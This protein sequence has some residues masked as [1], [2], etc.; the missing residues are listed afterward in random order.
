MNW[1]K[2]R[3]DYIDDDKYQE[4][5]NEL[6]HKGVVV[7]HTLIA[8]LAKKYHG[9]PQ[10]SL[11]IF[12]QKLRKSARVS[13]QNLHK[14]LTKLSLLFNFSF[15]K[16]EEK[17][18]FCYPKFLEIQQRYKRDGAGHFVA[19][20]EEDKRI[21]NKDKRIKSKVFSSTVH[22]VVSHLIKLMQRNDPK[23]KIPENLDTWF[24]EADRLIRLD[25]REK[26]EVLKVITF[27]QADPFWKSN[28]LSMG[29]L[30]EKYT[31]LK[32]KMEGNNGKSGGTNQ[33]TK[34]KD[35]DEGA[36]TGYFG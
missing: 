7:W 29:K 31:Q 11:E 18:H 4:C 36:P 28:I 1:F 24:L 26:D 9:D 27:S 19:I 25:K 12:E 34:E 8:L 10:E 23:V 33:F 2:L 15:T 20:Q 21:K 30:R 22:I 32:L 14:S 16:V 13:T 5:F 35:Y 17:L 3:S 6:G